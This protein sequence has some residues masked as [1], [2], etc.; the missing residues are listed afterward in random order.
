MDI[1]GIFEKFGI[2]NIQSNLLGGL[3]GDD[4][5]SIVFKVII[6]VL[7]IVVV[8]IVL[9]KLY[10][11]FCNC[12]PAAEGFGSILNSSNGTMSPQQFQM[13]FNDGKYENFAQMHEHMANADNFI[14]QYAASQNINLSQEQRAFIVKKS[15][16]DNLSEDQVKALVKRYRNENMDNAGNFVM[17]YAASQN[18]DLSQEQRAFIVKKS[19]D[20]NLSEDQVKALVRRY[21]NENMD[22]ANN[23]IRAYAADQNID[24]SNKQIAQI[25]SNASDNQLSEQ[26]VRAL[27][28]KYRTENMNNAD[29]FVRKYAADQDID[30]T[31]KQIARIV[32]ESNDND[33]DKKGTKALVRHYRNENMDNADDFVRKYAADQDIDL[34]SKQIA[35]IVKESND[36]DLDKKQTKAL[37]KKYRSENMDSSDLSMKQLKVIKGKLEDIDEEDL[38]R[39]E[40]KTLI[41]VKREIKDRRDDDEEDFDASDRQDRRGDRKDKRQDRRDDFDASDRQDRRGDRKDKRQDRRDDFDGSDEIDGFNIMTANQLENLSTGGFDIDQ[42]ETMDKKK[43]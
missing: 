36:N 15:S 24:L 3:D 12:G 37:V 41:K 40:K 11:N 7:I 19:S 26:Q 34:T 25:A 23:Y 5:E 2:S 1:Q 35:R 4:T 17:Q 14:R 10:N 22:N 33:L 18:V 30:L 39:D 27:V 42:F 16:D 8:C 13:K 20:D 29:D 38:T 31:S 32:K 21:K 6:L 43:N 9:Y 28:R